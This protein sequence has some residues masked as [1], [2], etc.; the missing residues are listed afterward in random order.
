MTQDRMQLSELLEKAGADDIVRACICARDG[1]EHLRIAALAGERRH[2]PLVGIGGLLLQ[3]G[4]ID[5]PAVES[6]RRTGL[7]TRHG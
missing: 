7:Q 2:R 4:P 5:G 6:R 1:A 3:L